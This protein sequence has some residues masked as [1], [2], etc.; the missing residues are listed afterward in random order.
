M[1]PSGASITSSSI[2][3]PQSTD[4]LLSSVTDVNGDAS[5]PTTTSASPESIVVD[6][7]KPRN[8]IGIGVGVGI[9]VLLLFA[10]IYLIWCIRRRKT[11]R[12]ENSATILL[13]LQTA[14]Q[15]N[16]DCPEISC[17]GGLVTFTWRRKRQQQP[18]HPQSPDSPESVWKPKGELESPD[19]CHHELGDG[20]GI[21]QEL[22]T[23]SLGSTFGMPGIS[24]AT[25]SPSTQL[26]TESP[27]VRLAGLDQWGRLQ[28]EVYEMEC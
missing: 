3:G 21:S 2:T 1:I 6:E 24:P 26:G 11:R 28:V 12:S 14:A 9:G 13:P 22:P 5:A 20:Q 7:S 15:G 18:A 25:G 10:V 19:K 8:W 16:H 17:C 23:P 27:V 4:G